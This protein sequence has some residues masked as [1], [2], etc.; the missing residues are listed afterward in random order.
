M[1][2][3]IPSLPVRFRR[4]VIQSQRLRFVLGFL[5]LYEFVYVRI[6]A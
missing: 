6:C 4:L 2:T 3:K 1:S 5:A